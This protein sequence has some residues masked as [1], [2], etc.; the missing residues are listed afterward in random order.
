MTTI[1]PSAVVAKQACLAE[2]VDVGPFTVI[3]PH[4]KIGAGTRIQS[5]VVLDGYTTLG[6]DC[7]IFPFASIGT[8]AQDLKYNGARTEVQI[9]DRTVLREYVT[10]NA[11]VN[12]GEVT[13]VGQDCFLMAYCHV[14]HL[15]H[16]GNHVIM[17]N[18][19]TLA[20]HVTI[21]DRA[22]IGG[23][24]AIHQF[25]QVGT[26]AMIGGCSRIVQDVPP[27]MLAVGNPAR[28]HGLNTVGL[29]RNG[30]DAEARRVLKEAYRLLYRSGLGPGEATRRIGEELGESPH[31]NHLLMFIKR[32]N[33]GLTG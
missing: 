33:R 20:G 11:S 7:R 13:S 5:H 17:A 1:H 16:V 12:E 9:G 30:F 8:E 18:G 15:C 6:K 22:V 4:V 19:S 28:V 26:F 32:S 21:E 24:S 23:L 29:K 2:D 14:A 25:T 31:V 3:G 27:Y 10:V